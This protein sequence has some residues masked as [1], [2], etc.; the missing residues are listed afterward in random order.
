[1]SVW[2]MALLIYLGLS[3]LFTVIWS[4]FLCHV[5]EREEDCALRRGVGD[6]LERA[7]QEMFQTRSV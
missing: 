6:E 3:A 2:I 5:K 1:M 7:L 4:V